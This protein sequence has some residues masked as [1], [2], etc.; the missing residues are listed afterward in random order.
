MLK[1][2][3]D[4]VSK[5]SILDDFTFYESRQKLMQDKRSKQQQVQKQVCLKF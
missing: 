1:I 5:T 4:H 3:K 2:F